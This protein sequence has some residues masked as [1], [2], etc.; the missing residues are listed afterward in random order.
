MLIIISKTFQKK[1]LQK[2]SKYF[3]TDDFINK[4]KNTSTIHLKYPHFKIKLKIKQA[5]FRWV[6]LIQESKYIIPIVL[7]LKKDKNCWEN[8]I[9]D[10]D[11]KEILNIEEQILCDIK[12][13]DY[14]IY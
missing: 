12:N 2:L 6:I 7:C 14:R 8:I 1:Y 3:S 5:E 10:K 11:E 4:L 13:K 9:W